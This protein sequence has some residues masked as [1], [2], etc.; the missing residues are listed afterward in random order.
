[1]RKLKL[2][3]ALLSLVVTPGLTAAAQTTTYEKVT[4]YNYDAR[5]RLISVTETFSERNDITLPPV[6]Y[7]PNSPPAGGGSN[8]VPKPDPIPPNTTAYGQCT[9]EYIEEEDDWTE[10]RCT[11]NTNTIEVCGLP[12]ASIWYN[13]IDS[14]RTSGMRLTGVTSLSSFTTIEL[15]NASR[16]LTITPSNASHFNN[17]NYRFSRSNGSFLFNLYRILNGGSFEVT[18]TCPN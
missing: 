17:G 3:F 10:T 11:A 8:S 6:S 14:Y 5:G 13:D 12:F 7:D 1:M 4:G 2:G 18:A 15:S 16:S 9:T